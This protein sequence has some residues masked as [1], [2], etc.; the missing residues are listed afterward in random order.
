MCVVIDWDRMGVG[1]FFIHFTIYGSWFAGSKDIA[2]GW[3]STV[4][5]ITSSGTVRSCRMR[6]SVEV[7]R[8]GLLQ[9]MVDEFGC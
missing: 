5:K 1:V 6:D 7:V 2:I 8:V 4:T 9:N 3:C